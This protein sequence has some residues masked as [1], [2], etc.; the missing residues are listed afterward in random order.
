MLSDLWKEQQTRMAIT[1][2]CCPA[3]G[4]L[5]SAPGL[6]GRNRASIIPLACRQPSGKFWTY[7]KFLTEGEI[8]GAP[9]L[10]AGQELR[11]AAELS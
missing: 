5:P 7:M 9:F 3:P 1:P 6:P 2:H 10:Q 8:V 4:A 11:G